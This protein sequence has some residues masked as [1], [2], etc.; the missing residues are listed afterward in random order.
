MTGSDPRQ[1]VIVGGGSA[2]WMTAAALSRFLE[3]GWRV[4]LVESDEIGTVGVGEATIPQMRLFLK[5]LG[6]DEDDFL[7]QTQ[8]TFKL[9]IQF[10]DW[11]RP[12]H[13]YFHSFWASGPSL[14]LLP[15]HQYW[16][17]ARAEGWAAPIERYSVMA[18]AAAADRFT[19]GAPDARLLTPALA[20]AYHIDASLLA[21]SLRG[22]A[23]A[24]G[25]VRVEGRVAR[26][27]L[28][29]G[30]GFVSHLEMQDGRR[31]EGEFFVDCSGF[32]AL[33]IGEALGVGFEDWSR[34]L[35]CDR[36][37]AAPTARA[38]GP[39]TPYTRATASSAGWRWRIPLQHR[40]GNGYVY[41]SDHLGDDDAR[42]EL[43]AG[44]EGPPLAEP[45]LLRFR[46]GK[47]HRFWEKNCVA[48]GLASG[49]MEP[50]ESTSIH[51]VQ[52]AV[53]RLLQFLP[54]E[55]PEAADVETYNRRTHFEYDRIR[56]FL[57]LHYK[58][59]ERGETPFW[60]RCRDMQVPDMLADRMRLFQSAGRVDRDNDELFTEASWQ[61]VLLGQGCEPRSRH[62][63]SDQLS[64]AEIRDFLDAVQLNVRR[65]VAA[66]PSHADYVARI[67]E[68]RA[69]A[70]G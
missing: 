17:R 16:L 47:R 36:A 41:C 55:R 67:A 50:L 51:L 9:G 52:S 58:A 56:D 63:L 22:Y 21:R 45:R 49:F 4:T 3:R 66:M 1:I 6:L 19:R 39:L 20:Y 42:A 54:G 11:L 59:T 31:V 14:G 34:W 10:R 38:P 12:G 70:P 57:I 7:R 24:R 37:L 15:F 64:D 29:G 27:A 48:L 2:G 61:Q 32:R 28:R 60:R 13:S 35:P 26:A 8:G 65:T 53:A 62:P 69:R 44:L 33:V 68:A 25:V 43:L 18:A 40:T 23:E 5:G 30:D 46:T